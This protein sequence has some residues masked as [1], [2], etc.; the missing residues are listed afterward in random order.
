MLFSAYLLR[1]VY[2]HI[3]IRGDKAICS[4]VWS[5]ENGCSTVVMSS[6]SYVTEHHL[7]A[8]I[9]TGQGSGQHTLAEM[10]AQV[11]V[12]GNFF[13]LST[14]TRVCVWLRIPVESM[15][16]TGYDIRET[17]LSALLVP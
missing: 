4:R 14:E 16:K 12:N 2:H 11:N 8:R 10:I 17:V 7:V 9:V 3:E 15:T 5:R 13:T 1:N 6:S